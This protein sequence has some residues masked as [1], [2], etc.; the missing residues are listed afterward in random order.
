M[1]RYAR[2]IRYAPIGERGQ[3]ALG[4]SSVAIVGAGALGSVIAQHLVR[5]GA[6]R[7]RIID[8]DI[9][10]W[11]N[12]QRQ[13]LYD[14]EDVRRML[15]KAEAAAVRLRAI[16]SSIT[17]E[18]VIADVTPANA[19][20]LLSDVDLIIDGSDNFT[21]RYLLN[22]ISIKHNIP[23]IYGGAVGASG[24]SM[25]IVPGET[26]CYRCIFPEQP[27]AG[28]ADTCETAGVI[29]PIVDVIG[30]LQAT[31]ALKLLSGNRQALHGTL[32]QVD[33]WQGQWMPLQIK[34]SRRAD[35]PACGKHHYDYLSEEMSHRAAA[36]LCGRHTVQITPSRPLEA[37]L[38]E[39]VNRLRPIG[40][41]EHNPF[42]MRLQLEQN[43]TF[44]LFPDGRALVQG[45]D[46]LT[47]ANRIYTELLGI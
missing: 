12:L 44:I 29:S 25:T 37:P 6:G 42:V 7:V 30:S 16:N 32:F 5:S 27:A 33:L 9:V 43:L 2:Q 8:R 14:E 1:N 45:T 46:D 19:E 35:C 34:E 47:A 36:A 11:S 28:A 15:P 38:H 10:D 22:D 31:E 41:I 39:L 17:I 21:V 13:S 18:S 4:G 26:P 20:S 23:W 40:P 24:M 3:S